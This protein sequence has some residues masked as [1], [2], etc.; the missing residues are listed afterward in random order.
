[1]IGVN[2]GYLCTQLAQAFTVHPSDTGPGPNGHEIRG[3]KGAVHGFK[4]PVARTTIPAEELVFIDHGLFLAH[5][6]EDGEC[7]AGTFWR[8]NLVFVPRNLEDKHAV[9]VAQKAIQCVQRE[10]VALGEALTPKQ[11]LYQHEMRGSGLMEI[12]NKTVDDFE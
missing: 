10:V 6:A 12:G 11:G 2:Q 8:W 4:K 1:M 3:L 5:F 7:A 9:A